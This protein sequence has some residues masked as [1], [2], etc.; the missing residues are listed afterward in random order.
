MYEEPGYTAVDADGND[1]TTDVVVDNPVDVEVPDTYTITYT[2]PTVPGTFPAT[3]QAIVLAYDENDSRTELADTLRAGYE[4]IGF[5]QVQVYS[6]PP[7]ILKAPAVVIGAA[8]P[9]ILPETMGA[10]KQAFRFNYD[11][12][13]IVGRAMPDIAY[14][15]LENLTLTT[16]G[17]LRSERWK[18]AEASAPTDTEWGGVTHVQS[19]MLVTSVFEKGTL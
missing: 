11:L 10:S 4:A 16:W 14:A 17:I 3:R 18:A 15:Q 7:D 5:N 2:L 9:W 6:Y 13:L 19:Q 1:V 12:A 8:D